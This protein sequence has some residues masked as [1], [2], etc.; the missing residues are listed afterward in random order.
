MKTKPHKFQALKLC[1]PDDS[2]A[3]SCYIRCLYSGHIVK[4]NE[5]V[6]AGWVADDN[7]EAYV[8]YYSPEGRAYLEKQNA[9]G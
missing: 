9:T 7:G 6:R 2:A 8:A 1:G 4:W 3:G 5:A